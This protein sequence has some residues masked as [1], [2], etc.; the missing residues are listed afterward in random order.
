MVSETEELTRKVEALLE[1]GTLTEI[2]ESRLRVPN[3][4][5]MPTFTG[6]PLTFKQISILGLMTLEF[7]HVALA[8]A[9]EKSG[10]SFYTR[11][12]E[13]LIYVYCSVDPYKRL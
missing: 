10:Y 12:P 2:V 3:E 4:T 1:E 7:Y 11:T 13:E 5:T 8:L 9:V 6:E